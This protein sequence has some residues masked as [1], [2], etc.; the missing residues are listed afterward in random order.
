MPLWSKSIFQLTASSPRDPIWLS[1]ALGNDLHYLSLNVCLFVCLF[2]CFN[3]F[4]LHFFEKYLLRKIVK[5]QVSIKTKEKKDPNFIVLHCLPYVQ[6]MKLISLLYNQIFTF[7]RAR[8]YHFVNASVIL[9]VAAAVKL[10]KG[11]YHK[12]Y[13]IQYFTV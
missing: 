11:D 8:C 5:D 1:P 6:A 13:Q 2:V 12:W 9:E 7:S 10:W 4:L 3:Q